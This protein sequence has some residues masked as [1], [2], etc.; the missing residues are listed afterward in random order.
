MGAPED[1]LVDAQ[2]VYLEDEVLRG[3]ILDSQS[4]EYNVDSV[5]INDTQFKDLGDNVE[6]TGNMGCKKDLFAVET[7]EDLPEQIIGDK[8]Q[9]LWKNPDENH[10]KVISQSEIM[11]LYESL[12][13][14]TDILEE[15]DSTNVE[16]QAHTHK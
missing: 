14:S 8:D 7:P 6:G 5:V 4:K 9:V 15:T 16:T 10:N 11:V 1:F 12:N 2:V 3:E 13:T